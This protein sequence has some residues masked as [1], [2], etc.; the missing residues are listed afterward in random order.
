MRSMGR[1]RQHNKDLP[2]GLYCYPGRSC[3]IQLGDMKPVA[4]GTRDRD[5]ATAVYW[6]F[7][8]QWDSERAQKRAG[9]IADRLQTAVQGGDRVTVAGYAAIWRA[10]RLSALLKKNGKPI[11]SKTRADYARMLENQIEPHAEFKTLA[12]GA[13][14]AKHLR[15]FLAR[16]IGSPNYYNN[17]KSLLSRMF[18]DA[19]A[20]AL[21]D[22]NPVDAVS[23]RPTARRDVYTP[24]D[25]Y[26]AITGEL[27]EWEARACDLI[28]L[29]SH[30]PGDVLRL[31]DGEPD[32]RYETRRGRKMVVLALR[33][34]RTGEAIDIYDYVDTAGGIEATLQWFRDW[35]K[36]Q[37]IISAHIICYPTTSRRRSIGKR[38]SVGYL[39]RRFAD[40]AKRVNLAGKYTPRDLRKKGLTDEARI[41]GKATNKGAHK[42]QAMREYYVVGG[43]PQRARNNLT[44]MRGGK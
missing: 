28:Y 31:K 16:W 11:A 27:E 24:L 9:V 2:P 35:K 23:R 17:M 19:I 1:P 7:R 13:T 32:V 36:R 15:A 14:R 33:R 40:A 41:A 38:V 3:Y 20:E 8:R 10:Q 21:L 26:L 34:A 30:S 42:T 6:E 18:E 25:H 5:E 12:I 43:L 4:L 44:V 39:S 22:I 37:D 29:A